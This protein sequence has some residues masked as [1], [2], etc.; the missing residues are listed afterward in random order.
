MP[1]YANLAIE[2]IYLLFIQ[3]SNRENGLSLRALYR[4]CLKC[5]EKK[6]IEMLLSLS[7]KE[8]KFPNLFKAH[9]KCL[10]DG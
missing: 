10:D 9:K 6:Q 1:I 5:R 8:D 3:R 4:N 7:I 2:T